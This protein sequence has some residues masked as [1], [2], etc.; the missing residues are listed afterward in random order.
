MKSSIA[1]PWGVAPGEL[2]GRWSVRAGRTDSEGTVRYDPSAAGREIW[3]SVPL[4]LLF[5]VS[6][7]PWAFTTA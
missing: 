3:N 6:D 4:S 2:A 7:P 1:P 5:N